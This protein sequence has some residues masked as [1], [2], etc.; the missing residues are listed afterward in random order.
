MSVNNSWRYQQYQKDLKIDLAE[1][2]PF[3]EIEDQVAARL[4]YQYKIWDLGKKR[5]VCIRSTV[6]SYLPRA[7]DFSEF[8]NRDE[9][10]KE[11]Q[12]PK[13]IYQNTYALVEYEGNKSNW[14]Q[15]LD[16]KMAQSITKEVQ[17]NSCKLSRWV[18]ESLLAGAD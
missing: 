3:I 2:D 9:E 12:K 11:I 8:E 17:D 7:G 5:K 16:T 4:G 13:P 15:N 1:K 10:G 18:V 14:K 6:H